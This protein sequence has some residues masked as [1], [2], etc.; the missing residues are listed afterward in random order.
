MNE[1]S[2]QNFIKLYST[3]KPVVK[4]KPNKLLATQIITSINER[5]RAVKLKSTQY[6]LTNDILIMRNFNSINQKKCIQDDSSRYRYFHKTTSSRE[7]IAKPLR[8]ATI[9]HPSKSGKL[10]EVGKIFLDLFYLNKYTLITSIS[11]MI[12]DVEASRSFKTNRSKMIRVLYCS[13]LKII[14]RHSI[15][16]SLQ[17]IQKIILIY[18]KDWHGRVTYQNSL[19]ICPFYLAPNK[20]L[21]FPS[22]IYLLSLLLDQL[23]LGQ[24]FSIQSEIKDLLK[25]EN[26]GTDHKGYVYVDASENICSQIN[27]LVLNQD[28]VRKIEMN[29]VIKF[30]LN[31]LRET[32]K[33]SLSI[34][35]S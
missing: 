5:R 29:H 28:R 9:E 4:M 6:L 31:P 15:N 21:S 18:N 25:M 35:C 22:D 1:S 20:K 17:A 12:D 30:W 2:Q 16:S 27:K 10:N 3:P 32:W 7:K 19:G 26:I 14:S 33:T 8:S 23:S 13:T 34:S 24:Y 11:C